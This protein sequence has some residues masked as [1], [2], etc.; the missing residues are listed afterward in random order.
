MGTPHAVHASAAEKFLLGRTL[1][2]IAADKA[3]SEKLFGLLRSELPILSLG[4]AKADVT[5]RVA[6]RRRLVTAFMAK[7]LVEPVA[8]AARADQVC[9]A[10]GGYTRRVCVGKHDIPGFDNGAGP[11]TDDWYEHAPISLPVPKLSAR[12]QASGEARFTCDGPLGH[13]TAYAALAQA[14]EVGRIVDA[15][16]TDKAADSPGVIRIVTTANIRG[17][18]NQ[19]GLSPERLLAEVGGAGITYAGEPVCIVVAHT[20][21]EAHEAAALV[22][23]SYRGDPD[24]KAPPVSLRDAIKHKV[25][26]PSNPATDH[27]ERHDNKCANLTDA[28]AACEHVVSGE[29]EYGTQK[30]FPMEV[31]CAF[32]QPDEGGRMQVCNNRT[33]HTLTRADQTAPTPTSFL[34]LTLT[35]TLMLT[36][37]HP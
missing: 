36:L 1:K 29:V 13:R 10:P 35:P 24:P 2:A 17:A 5:H 3:Q 28:L 19:S 8:R 30:H 9:G 25:L 34:P 31:Q 20:K 7:F 12:L 18:N 22:T 33:P 16:H 6:H 23:V 32:A 11:L 4:T 14:Y 21:R 27:L 26:H 15:L 37:T